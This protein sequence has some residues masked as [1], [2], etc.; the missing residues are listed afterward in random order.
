MV[1]SSSPG[2][3]PQT[4]GVARRRLA[5]ADVARSLEVQLH[6]PNLTGLEFNR[7]CQQAVR[8]GVAAVLCRPKMVGT[9][10]AVVKGSGVAVATTVDHHHPG[11]AASSPTQLRAHA[12]E[13]VDQGANELSIVVTRDALAHGWSPGAS[14]RIETVGEVLDSIGGTTRVLLHTDDLPGR[15][16]TRV[17]QEASRAGAR[18]IEGGTWAGDQTAFDQL[19]AMREALPVGTLLKWA[20]PVRSLPML[21]LAVAH[22]ADRCNAQQP[23]LILRQARHMHSAGP[24]E[25]PR[26]GLDF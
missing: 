14:T 20:S 13:L 8:L 10:S 2:H 23:H 19:R 21:L 18:L 22:G 1:A 11:G 4:S 3:G 9:A 17:C 16:L 5:V 15:Q 24:I 6:H 7:M 25:V 26:Q 12:Q